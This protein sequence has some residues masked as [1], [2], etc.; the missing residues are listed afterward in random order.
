MTEADADLRNEERCTPELLLRSLEEAGF[1]FDL[2]P[3]PRRP[4]GVRMKVPDGVSRR[5]YEAIRALVSDER[6]RLAG[7]LAAREVLGGA[8]RYFAAPGDSP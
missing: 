8:E 1:E 6:F 7:L 5:E 4:L 2:V 3:G